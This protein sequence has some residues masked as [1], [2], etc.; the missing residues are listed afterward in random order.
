MTEVLQTTKSPALHL[1][2]HSA[3]RRAP[4]SAS[5]SAPHF[6]IPFIDVVEPEQEV[7][8]AVA[9]LL[10]VF[11]LSLHATAPLGVRWLQ[12]STEGTNFESQNE[13]LHGEQPLADMCPSTR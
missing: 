7:R 4:K 8:L 9:W 11:W 10:K 2:L 13:K 3:N 6:T 12:A 1:T 5:K